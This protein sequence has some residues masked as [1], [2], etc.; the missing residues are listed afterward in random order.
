MQRPEVGGVIA[1]QGVELMTN[2][3]EEFAR[4]IEADRARFAQVIKMTGIKLEE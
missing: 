2:S 4:M 1:S 3:P